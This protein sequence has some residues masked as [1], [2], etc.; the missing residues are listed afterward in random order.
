MSRLAVA[1]SGLVFPAFLLAQIP[2]KLRLPGDVQ[3]L[4][5][6]LN[7]RLN[8]AEDNYSGH[9][10]IEVAVRQPSQTIWLNAT[11]LK[12]TKA[13]V[14][15]ST[16]AQVVNGGRDFVGLQFPSALKPGKTRLDIDFTG[17]FELKDVEGLFR[18]ADGGN[19]YVMTQFEPTSARRAFPCFDEP[20][21]KVPFT[22]TF[23]VPKDQGAFSNT[24]VTSD[25]AGPDGFR[26]VHFAET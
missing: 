21:Y 8:P 4:R 9:V 15:S 1:I 16:T 11:E 22:L 17:A 19:R 18:Q 12:L 2:P 5:Y 13:V 3:P 25:T 23:T 6:E 7:L 24:P 20:G 14:G 26:K 10:A